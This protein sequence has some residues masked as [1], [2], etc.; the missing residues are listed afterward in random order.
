MRL[1]INY[2]KKSG[3]NTS[4][5]GLN[6]TLLNNQETTEEIKEEIKKYLETNDNENTMTQNL[7]DAAKAVLSG[8]FTAIQSYLKK[9]E[10]AQIN[11]LTLHLK[12]LEK[13]EKETPKLVEG[14]KS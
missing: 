7:C 2:R 5:W 1:D 12:Q 11:N 4:T 6:N 14:K 10:T 9:Q 3:K 13:E 8:K